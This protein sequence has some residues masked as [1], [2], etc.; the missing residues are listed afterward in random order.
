MKKRIYF[1]IPVSIDWDTASKCFSQLFKKYAVDV[2]KRD[3]YY[4]KSWIDDC[5]AFVIM[6]PNGKW[7]YRIDELPV[8]CRREIKKAERLD[9]P[10]YLAYKPMSNSIPIFYNTR[11]NDGY[12]IGLGG[13]S[14][15]LY[16]EIE[17]CD[18]TI[19]KENVKK[20]IT[21]FPKQKSKSY[22]LMTEDYD[23]GCVN[24]FTEQR[25]LLLLL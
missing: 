14:G 8:G 11:I 9:K 12:I 5:D 13:T 6:L 7:S 22:E 18:D 3:H 1:S 21:V 15:D 20:S 2:W 25:L 19:V 16:D 24:I 10:I 23:D 17:P 4:N